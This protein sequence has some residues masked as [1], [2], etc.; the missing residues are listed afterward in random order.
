M[1]LAPI[2]SHDPVRDRPAQGAFNCCR[3]PL[4]RS[5]R[6]AYLAGRQL[7]GHGECVRIYNGP[8]SPKAIQGSA[9]YPGQGDWYSA[10]L[11][12]LVSS[13]LACGGVLFV[14]G[15]MGSLVLIYKRFVLASDLACYTVTVDHGQLTFGRYSDTSSWHAVSALLVQH[16][17]RSQ[18]A[19]LA[20]LWFCWRRD[21]RTITP[22][23]DSVVSDRYRRTDSLGIPLQLGRLDCLERVSSKFRS[24]PCV[25]GTAC[26]FTGSGDVNGVF[27]EAATP[28]GRRCQ[29][30]TDYGGILP[31]FARTCSYDA[32]GR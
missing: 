15:C 12:V 2:D 4:N 29:W 17:I 24:A 16:P 13:K 9:P 26:I 31:D 19:F 27:R 8:Y 3:L 23:I 30:T 5:G 11:Y 21:A 10:V 1:A 6:A 28:F 7:V 20:G 22:K 25:Q 32:N 14:L 18:S